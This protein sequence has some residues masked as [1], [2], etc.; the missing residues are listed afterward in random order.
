MKSAFFIMVSNTLHNQASFDSISCPLLVLALSSGAPNNDFS[1]TSFALSQFY[2]KVCVTLSLNSLSA[3][4]LPSP[5]NS[6][7][8]SGPSS[9][10]MYLIPYTHKNTHVGK[11]NLSS[12]DFTF[13]CHWLMFGG[14][15]VCYLSVSAQKM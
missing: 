8:Q 5:S 1:L 13:C 9:L 10:K 6:P 4:P 3:L 12:P 15:R 2:V 14:I 11:M 7:H